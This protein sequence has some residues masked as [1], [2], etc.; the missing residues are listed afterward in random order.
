MAKLL[1]DRHVLADV[2]P[3]VVDHALQ[4]VAVDPG[5]GL[6]S[7]VGCSNSFPVVSLS[8]HGSAS[9]VIARHASSTSAN[10]GVLAGPPDAK[11]SSMSG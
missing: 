10:A 11:R 2:V 3:V 7:R 9:A 6:P 8:S 4:E 5:E 1:P